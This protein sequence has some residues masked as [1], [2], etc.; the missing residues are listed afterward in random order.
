MSNH[1]SKK[2]RNTSSK[3]DQSHNTDDQFNLDRL[4]LSQDF[5][6]LAGTKKQIT[7]VLVGKPPRQSFFRTH[8][9]ESWRFETQVL[10]L[11]E[12]KETFLVDLP[13]WEELSLELVPKC[14]FAAITLQ[15]S[16]FIW[17]IRLPGP[18]GRHDTWNKSALEIATGVAISEWVRL[19]SNQ[20]LGLYEPIVAKGIHPDPQWPDLTFQ[21][22]LRIA[23]KDRFIQSL[24]HPVTRKLRGEL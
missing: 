19:V 3:K 16:L 7:T 1:K 5:P 22:I 24:D 13:L 8:P 4:R 12:T 20:E 23:F 21:E 10:E 2:Q 15:N 11:K 14:L 6:A 9:D 18:D 17:S